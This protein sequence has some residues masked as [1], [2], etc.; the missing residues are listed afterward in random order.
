MG[1]NGMIKYGVDI[2]NADKCPKCGKDLVNGICPTCG[3]EP[4]EKK[5][6]KKDDKKDN[7][8]NE[9]ARVKTIDVIRLE[10]KIKKAYK[11]ICRTLISA[12]QYVIEH[13]TL[14]KYVVLSFLDDLI[15]KENKLKE[16]YKQYLTVA[17]G[18]F[19][20]RAVVGDVITDGLSVISHMRLRGII[21]VSFM[22]D[23][24]YKESID[25]LVPILRNI[26]NDVDTLLDE[27][28]IA[29]DIYE[30]EFI[31]TLRFAAL[32][33]EEHLLDENGID[34]NAL[35]EDIRDIMKDYLG[36]D[37]RMARRAENTAKTY[38]AVPPPEYKPVYCKEY[39]SVAKRYYDATSGNITPR[40]EPFLIIK[41]NKATIIDY[42]CKLTSLSLTNAIHQ[43]STVQQEK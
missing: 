14:N 20:E 12:S 7:N 22:T 38:T 31:D 43:A 37:E 19:M 24:T 6:E 34:I 15:E 9:F 21:N 26:Q 11:S 28:A 40:F 36:L 25:A 16:L 33:A 39:K 10:K 5:D 1:D 18:D 30:M 23:L 4:L 35:F 29:I 13:Q 8:S 41:D 27:I 17:N 3:S 2:P 32:T 42:G